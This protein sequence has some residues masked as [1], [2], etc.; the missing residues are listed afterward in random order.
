MATEQDKRLWHTL[1][2][3]RNRRIRAQ[4][5]TV[6]EALALCSYVT[7]Q[8]LEEYGHIKIEMEQVDVERGFKGVVVIFDVYREIFPPGWSGPKA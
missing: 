5:D 1:D 3:R 2:R 7:E 6:A 4:R 8:A